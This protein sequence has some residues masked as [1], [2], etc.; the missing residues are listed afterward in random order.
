MTNTQGKTRRRVFTSRQK[1]EA[2]LAIWSERRQPKEICRDLEITWAMLNQWQQKALSGMM[3][4]L[5]PRQVQAKE[6]G[7][8]LGPRLEKLLEKTAMQHDK[9]SKL[10]R[11]LKEIQVEKPSKPDRVKRS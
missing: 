2:V 1:C 7:P 8:V 3:D 11:R 6:R 10:S 4:A 5:E 9:A